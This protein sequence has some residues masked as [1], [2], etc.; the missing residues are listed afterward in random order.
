MKTAGSDSPTE[1]EPPVAV[2]LAA[3]EGRRLRDRG[4][5]T[6]KPLIRLAGLSLAERCVCGLL[7]AGIRQ[8]VVILGHLFRVQRAIIISSP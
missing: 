2:I 7:Q 5:Q 1:H 3:G 6:P 4:S 8:F